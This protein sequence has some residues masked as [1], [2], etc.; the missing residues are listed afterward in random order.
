MN[1]EPLM[2]FSSAYFQRNLGF[3]AVVIA[4]LCTKVLEI[5]SCIES[6]CL[7]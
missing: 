5:V 7:H 4:I 3:Q 2:E 6:M 1:L